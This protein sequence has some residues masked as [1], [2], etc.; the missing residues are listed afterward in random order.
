MFMF[1]LNWF[2]Q[3]KLRIPWQFWMVNEVCFEL[4][5]NIYTRWLPVIIYEV[6]T[7]PFSLRDTLWR[8]DVLCARRRERTSMDCIDWS[9]TWGCCYC[10]D[11]SGV[12][13]RWQ[14]Y[15][16]IATINTYPH[17]IIG[18]FHR[19]CKETK[20][21]LAWSSPKLRI[22][23]V[24]S[25]LMGEWEGRRSILWIPC[26][27]AS[28]YIST[29]R[30]VAAKCYWPISVPCLIYGKC[31]HAFSADVMVICLWCRCGRFPCYSNIAAYIFNTEIVKH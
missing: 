13:S 30:N 14:A 31:F 22:D 6:L 29:G 16:L 28:R 8:G 19:A 10:S 4:V 23:D 18:T 17:D 27:K 7:I 24:S 20:L 26:L 25:T 2:P 9:A 11:L 5:N 1:I 15:Y 12:L 21:L 3:G